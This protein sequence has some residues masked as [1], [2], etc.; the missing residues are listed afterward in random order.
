MARR[1]QHRGGWRLVQ[2]L[3]IAGLVSIS[4]AAYLLG[5]VG[6]RR[7]DH[8]RSAISDFFAPLMSAVSGPAHSLKTAIADFGGSLDVYEHNR[9]L[10][11]DIVALSRWRERALQL[12]AENARLRALNKVTL[13]PRFDYIT[14]QVVGSSDGAFTQSVTINAGRRDGVRAG[15]VAMDG[16]AVVGR[17]V[18]LGESASRVVLITDA[19]SRI[20]AT[21]E[22]GG[23]KAILMGD[24]SN[25]PQLRFVSQPGSVQR[26]HRVVTSNHAGVFPK[27]LPLGQIVDVVDGKAVVGLQADFRQLEFVRLVIEREDL[28]IDPGAVLVIGRDVE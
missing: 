7:V 26:G 1:E 28:S 9:K 22:P 21:L 16:T 25:Q 24:N 23:A 3:V 20:P 27:G 17:V 5:A 6:D 8:S 12:D 19:A 13:A 18:S 11:K 15:T 2:R 4:A 14:A 10:R